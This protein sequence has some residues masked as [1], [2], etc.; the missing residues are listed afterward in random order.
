MRDRTWFLRLYREIIP[1]LSEG[2]IDRTAAQ[3]M[4]YLICTMI[5]IVDLACFGVSCAKNLV[6]VDCVTSF[7]VQKSK[8]IKTFW[9]LFTEISHFN[10]QVG[11]LQQ[12]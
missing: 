2:I 8:S 5:F 6:S 11:L 7:N 12:L 9:R 10:L 4:L 1:E 3:T